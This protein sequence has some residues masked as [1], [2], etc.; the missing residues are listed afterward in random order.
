LQQ[1]CDPL[2]ELGRVGRLPVLQQAL[3]DAQ[4]EDGHRVR[5][6]RGEGRAQLAATLGEPLLR[7]QPLP[8]ILT[9]QQ[10]DQLGL[11]LGERE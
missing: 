7:R 3:L 2:L 4:L 6:R 8:P 11:R 10:A 1:G 5:R 9:Q